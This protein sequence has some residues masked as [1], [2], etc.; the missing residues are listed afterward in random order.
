MLQSCNEIAVRADHA[1]AGPGRLYRFQ[2]ANPD[3]NLDPVLLGARLPEVDT[4]M[5]A[6]TKVEEALATVG[7]EPNEYRTKG[8]YL[9]PNQGR[10]VVVLG[11]TA[12]FHFIIPICG[13]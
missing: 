9:H 13:G 11:R 2:F 1:I 12:I 4:F 8:S 3:I 7:V 6:K 5:E 10:F